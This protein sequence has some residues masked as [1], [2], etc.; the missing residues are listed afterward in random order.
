MATDF[1]ANDIL[2]QNIIN[3]H[4]VY[5]KISHDLKP[6]IGQMLCK[7]PS[8]RITASNCLLIHDRLQKLS[9]ES[10]FD[11][12]IL[13]SDP[14][15]L[16]SLLISEE[17]FMKEMELYSDYSEIMGST[18]DSAAVIVPESKPPIVSIRKKLF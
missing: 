4:I 2:W 9:K 12:M 7:D 11:P 18:S 15:P 10:D 14:D 8:L 1:T 13:H 6:L 3:N 5:D 16:L 17:I